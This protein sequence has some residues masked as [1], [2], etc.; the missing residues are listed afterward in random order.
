M[1]LRAGLR[2]TPAGSGGDSLSR[3]PERRGEACSRRAEGPDWGMYLRR[4]WPIRFMVGAVIFFL[5]GNQ[6]IYFS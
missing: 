3:E 1:F 4:S 5:E 2:Y 6:E